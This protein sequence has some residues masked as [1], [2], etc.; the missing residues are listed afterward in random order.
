MI[1][2]TEAARLLRSTLL[3][4]NEIARR[5]GYEDSLYFSKRFSRRYKTS[6]SAFRK[7]ARHY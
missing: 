3:P 1:R 2:L 6:P 5:V 7:T 4:I